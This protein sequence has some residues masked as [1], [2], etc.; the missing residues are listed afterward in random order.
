MIDKNTIELPRE[1]LERL[2][3]LVDKLCSEDEIITGY[4]GSSGDGDGSGYG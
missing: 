4:G 1:W 3:E 2:V